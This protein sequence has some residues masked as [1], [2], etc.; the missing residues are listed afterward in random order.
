MQ[1][2]EK[3]RILTGGLILVTVGVLIL[4]NQHT[5]YVFSRTWPVF[6]IV[7]SVGALIQSYRD[8]GGWLIGIAGVVF[9]VMS[10]WFTAYERFANYGLPVLLIALGI[11]FMFF[12]KSKKY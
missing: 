7:I 3:T 6:L 9:L 4:L 12:K 10:N 8:I 11:F 5:D 2:R 1:A